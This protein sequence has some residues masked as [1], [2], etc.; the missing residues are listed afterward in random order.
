MTKAR[1]WL[2]ACRST[3]KDHSLRPQTAWSDEQLIATRCEPSSPAYK[4]LLVYA[5]GRVRPLEFAVYSHACC[6][7][8]CR[9][10]VPSYC[11]RKVVR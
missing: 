10:N 7:T 1:T 2:S 9:I 5:A 8:G 3:A 6:G 11:V 4:S